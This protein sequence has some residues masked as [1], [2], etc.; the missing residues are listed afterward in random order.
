[1]SAL[2]RARV[3]AERLRDRHLRLAVTGLRRS[4]KTVFTTAIAAHLLHG[5]AGLPFLRAAHAG[6]YLGARPLPVGRDAFPLKEFT[7]DLRADPPRW[8]AATERLTTLKLEIRFKA[9]GPLAAYLSGPRR[10]YLDIV[11]YPGE[12]LL[13]L[14]LLREDYAAF[15]RRNLALCAREPRRGAFKDYLAAVA[16]GADA[17][18]LIAAWRLGLRAAQGELGLSV[19]QPGR[20]V[21]HDGPVPD[22]GFAP[23]PDPTHPAWGRMVAGYDRYTTTLVRPFYAD[24]FSRFDR[25]AVLVDLFHVLNLGPARF[26][27][28]AQALDMILE[29]FRYGRQGLLRRL[30]SP[31]IE[32]VLFAA[33]K[34]D[35][36]AANQHPNLKHLLE[37]MIDPARRHP[38]FEG[39]KEEV[40]A[41]ASLRATDTVKTE[42]N[43]QVLSCV[44]GRLKDEGADRVVFPGE[45][46]PDLPEDE[47]WQGGRF[48]F[49]DFRPRPL[50]PGRPHGHLRLDQALEFL[51]GDKLK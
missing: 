41:I 43:G 19:V 5:A 45:L 24:H 36:V 48:R 21:A 15:S 50:D 6:R 8:P 25:Q 51:I 39:I 31:R 44:R 12:W 23:L 22:W 29:S 47:D 35:H 18:A 27:D 34:A 38:R 2:D 42:H 46:P 32:R 4:G 20:L 1:M 9:D 49:F 7:A 13:D 10:L 17:T 26:A 16:G 11:D 3:A 40:M 28:A 30:F 37:R 14:P 33:T